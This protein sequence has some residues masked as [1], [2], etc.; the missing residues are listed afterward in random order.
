MKYSLTCP[1]CGHVISVDAVDDKEAV[2]KLLKTAMDH[3]HEKH[4]E[5]ASMPAEE[6]RK[7]VETGMKKGVE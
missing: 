4:P 2:D 5:M 1:L 7:M 6:L 3:G